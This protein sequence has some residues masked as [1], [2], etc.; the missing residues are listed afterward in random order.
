MSL[1]EL[2]R[3]EMKVAEEYS[4]AIT[5]AA[6]L[7]CCGRSGS[8]VL[9]PGFQLDL[10]VCAHTVDHTLTCSKFDLSRTSWNA[11]TPLVK[12]CSAVSGDLV[13]IIYDVEDILLQ[14]YSGSY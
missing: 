14:V 10:L 12:K 3:S 13:G 6:R 2:K 11:G 5:Q 7:S 8:S 4:W 9:E 1:Q